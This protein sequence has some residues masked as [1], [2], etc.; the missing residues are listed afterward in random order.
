MRTTSLKTIYLTIHEL[1][2]AVVRYIQDYRGKM[3]TEGLYAHLM[4]N[5]WSMDWA[6]EGEEFAI[7]MDGEIEDNKGSFTIE[8][9]E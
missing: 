6:S 7:S 2:E 5:E 9:E 4:N 3:G 8:S 1:K